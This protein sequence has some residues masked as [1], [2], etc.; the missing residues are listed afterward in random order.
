MKKIINKIRRKLRKGGLLPHE[1]GPMQRLA[2]RHDEDCCAEGCCVRETSTSDSN[3]DGNATNR[4]TGK[5]NK[6]K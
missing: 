2:L 3:E 1:L 4:K 6:G 5:T